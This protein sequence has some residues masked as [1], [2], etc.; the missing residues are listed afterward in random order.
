MHLGADNGHRKASKEAEERLKILQEAAKKKRCE[1]PVFM[2]CPAVGCAKAFRGA[3][4]W[5]ERMEHVAGHLGRAAA[6]KEEDVLFGGDHDLTLTN[7]AASPDVGVTYPLSGGGWQHRN[8][9]KGSGS[10][11]VASSH[12]VSSAN[13]DQDAEGEDCMFEE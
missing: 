5:D 9:L 10:S 2:E 6:G 4:A 1:L 12:N 3:N 13:G 11:G 7:W 8:P